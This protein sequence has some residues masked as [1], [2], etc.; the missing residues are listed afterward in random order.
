M[1]KSMEERLA[2]IEDSITRLTKM[3]GCVFGVLLIL[4]KTSTLFRKGEWSTR[5]LEGYVES[6]SRDVEYSLT[7]MFGA[8]ATTGITLSM[9]A[10]YSTTGNFLSGVLSLVFFALTVFCLFLAFRYN[11]RASSE[12]KTFWAQLPQAR[13]QS[14]NVKEEAAALDD[15]M[16]QLLAEW[17]KLVPN[18][19]V[20]EPKSG[21]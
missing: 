6:S 14:Q 13:E 8:I 16:A 12:R 9:T 4:H 1:E 20:A 18:D 15:A 11:R 7:F 10:V 2:G 21:D 17:K 3:Q 19:R 5:L